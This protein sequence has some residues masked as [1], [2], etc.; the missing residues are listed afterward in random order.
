MILAVLSSDFPQCWLAEAFPRLPACR[1]MVTAC[2]QDDATLAGNAVDIARVSSHK[3]A[4][5]EPL[6]PRPVFLVKGLMD[7]PLLG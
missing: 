3:I 1:G 6:F 7:E 5:S 4:L 2:P